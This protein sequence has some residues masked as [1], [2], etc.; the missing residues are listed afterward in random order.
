VN[1]DVRITLHGCNWLFSGVLFVAVGCFVEGV[2]MFSEISPGLWSYSEQKGEPGHCMSLHTTLDRQTIDLIKPDSRWL[3]VCR[4]TWSVR[5]TLHDLRTARSVQSWVRDN[6]WGLYYD[7]GASVRF[8]TANSNYHSFRGQRFD[9]IVLHECSVPH[10]LY[11]L[12]EMSTD[13]PKPVEPEHEEF[14][15]HCMNAQ[16]WDCEGKLL[17]VLESTIE[18]SVATAN[19]KAMAAV[20]MMLNALRRIVQHQDYIGGSMASMSSTRHIAAQAIQHATGEVV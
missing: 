4:D 7:D 6:P 3:I 9:G 13:Q 19:A 5:Q 12:L 18:P 11:R 8:R 17:A 16:V 14:L 2:N 20:P 1:N 10:E 15:F